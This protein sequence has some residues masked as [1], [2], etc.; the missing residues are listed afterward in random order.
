M[1]RFLRIGTYTFGLYPFFACAGFFAA[2]VATYLQMRAMGTSPRRENQVMRFLPVAFL[3]GAGTAYF[4]DMLL[5]G[6]LAALKRP[7]GYG[8]TFYGWLIGVVIMIVLYGA[9]AKIPVGYLLNLLLPPIALGHAFGR[10]GCFCG[11]CCF[12]RPTSSCLGVRYPPGSI[13]Y[14][15]CGGTPLIPVQ[16]YECVLLLLIYFILIRF[17]RFRHRAAWYLILMPTERFFIEFLRADYRGMF[18]QSV[19]SPSQC[20]SIPF[21]I[22]GVVM[23]CR[24]RRNAATV[25]ARRGKI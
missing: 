10:I 17:V 4:T 24:S 21:L 11:G 5:K 25:G 7:G 20:M 23:L 16:L 1:F 14:K 13:P 9:A 18:F 2:V 3:L 6:G 12:G 8:L 15:V 22:A 19:L